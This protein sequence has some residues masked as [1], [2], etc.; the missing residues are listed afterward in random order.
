MGR[1]LFKLLNNQPGMG[2][3]QSEQADAGLK[4]IPAGPCS[5]FSGWVIGG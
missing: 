1:G 3:D 4:A 5:P 2:T